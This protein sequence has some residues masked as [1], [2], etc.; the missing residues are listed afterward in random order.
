MFP[1]G[2]FLLIVAFLVEDIK[3]TG[4]IPG[5]GR[6]PGGGH[7]NPLQYSCLENPMDR[8]AWKLQST[9]LQRDGQDWSDSAGR[10]CGSHIPASLYASDFLFKTG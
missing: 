10:M 8:G 4:S 5:S 6:A 1:Q 3:D 2:H 9:E 7:D